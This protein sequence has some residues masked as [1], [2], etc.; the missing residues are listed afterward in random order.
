[1]TLESYYL[2][3]LCI[4]TLHQCWIDIGVAAFHSIQM[5]VISVSPFPDA[6]QAFL[7]SYNYF[8]ITHKGYT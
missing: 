1:M 3:V 2:P 6:V 8:F 4:S 5:H 7:Q